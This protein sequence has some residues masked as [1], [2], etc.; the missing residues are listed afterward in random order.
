MENIEKAEKFEPKEAP[1]KKYGNQ[2]QIAGA[3][4]I[5]GLLIAGAILLKGNGTP[6]LPGA[7]NLADIK[8]RKVAQDEHILGNPEAKVVLVEYS[9]TECPFS[10]RFHTTIN[11]LAKEKGSDIA[12]VYRHFPIAQLHPKAFHEAV[13]TEC[14]YEQGGNEVFWK[15]LDEVYTRTN[16]N[17]SLDPKELP[18][19]AESLGLDMTKFNSCLDTE[20]YA[21]KVKADIKS[22]DDIGVNGT[23]KSFILKKGK[24]VDTVEG[25]YPYEDVLGKINKALK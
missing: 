7:G 8:I 2:N 13:A 21:D 20:K 17:N 14:A 10:K 18:K 11:Q 16:S 25:A 3:I 6:T 19:I 23:P 4:I 9:D 15:Y 5:A 22:G 12:L 1:I 24:V